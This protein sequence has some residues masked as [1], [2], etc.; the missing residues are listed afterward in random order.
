MC[1]VFIAMA[2]IIIAVLQVDSTVAQ[3]GQPQPAGAVPARSQCQ[4]VSTTS[5]SLVSPSQTP[6]ELLPNRLMTVL[7]TC[8]RPSTITVH[9]EDRRNSL[10]NGRAEIALVSSGSSGGIQ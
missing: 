5:G 6:T 7:V 10:Q 1:N 8:D 4:I 3:I 2:G 9:T